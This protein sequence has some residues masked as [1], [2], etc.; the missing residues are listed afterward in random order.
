MSDAYEQA[1]IEDEVEVNVNYIAALAPRLTGFSDRM[2]AVVRVQTS[3]T[4][5]Q[6]CT[7]CMR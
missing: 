2:Q 6:P 7:S 1:A 3:N 4:S 5:L